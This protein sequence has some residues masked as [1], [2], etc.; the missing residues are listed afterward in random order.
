MTDQWYI[1]KT[2]TRT[3]PCGLG[4]V[5][6]E[7]LV[8]MAIRE[9][10]MTATVPRLVVFYRTK[11]DRA[12]NTRSKKESPALRGMVFL[13]SPF[14]VP[15]GHIEGV[16]G[17][18]R[19]SDYE[20]ATISGRAFHAF[21]NRIEAVYQETLEADALTRALLAKKAKKEVVK[22]KDGLER[23]KA[24]MNGAMSEAA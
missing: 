8:A 5:C 22:F 19:M 17:Y 20:Y 6:R 18:M 12:N 16:T 14:A 3:I 13:Q 2:D 15:V 24:R 21:A 4:R 23:L 1:I 10:G 7:F 11:E 9:M